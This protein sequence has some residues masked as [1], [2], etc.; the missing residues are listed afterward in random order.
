M[1]L[2]NDFECENG[3]I[4][5]HF[6]DHSINRVQCPHC[7]LLATRKLAA[8]RSKLE[9]ITGAFPTAS[10]RWAMVHE[11]ANRVAQSKSFY[12]G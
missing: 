12:E 9:G 4:S 6:V 1:K 3:H 5:E 2:M 11:Q 7:D 10:D 8:P